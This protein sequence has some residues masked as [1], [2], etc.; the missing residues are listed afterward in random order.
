MMSSGKSELMAHEIEQMGQ[1]AGHAEQ[2][3]PSLEPWCGHWPVPSWQDWAIEEAL[4]SP[5]AKPSVRQI[6]S[7]T[8]ITDLT[9]RTF[10]ESFGDSNDF[11]IDRL[12][13]LERTMVESRIE[14]L[15]RTTRPPLSNRELCLAKGPFRAP[16][17]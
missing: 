15:R 14:Y 8:V 2:E 17:G 4:L 6:A 16:C 13:S 7:T 3:I 10:A 9:G 12:Y 11:L 1:F 5:P